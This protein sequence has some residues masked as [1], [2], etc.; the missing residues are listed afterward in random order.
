MKAT[1]LLIA[2]FLFSVSCKNK[3]IEVVAPSLEEPVFDS[4]LV[5][6]ISDSVASLY[7]KI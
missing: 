3:K 2:V 7:R 6:P 4:S 1:L 5:R